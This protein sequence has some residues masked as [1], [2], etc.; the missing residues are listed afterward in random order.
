MSDAFGK[1]EVGQVVRRCPFDSTKP[2]HWIE[3]ELVGEDGNPIPW[4]EY[5]LV[6][7]NGDRVSGFL[8][9]EG[10]ARA[11]GF[12]QS[13][14]CQVSFPGLDRDAWERIEVLPMKPEAG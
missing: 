4:E 11:Q 8:D 12:E 1:T 6:L 14:S 2:D 3:I 13:G 5:L 9:E 7:P 10:F